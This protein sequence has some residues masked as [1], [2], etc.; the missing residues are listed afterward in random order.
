MSLLFA[1][2]WAGLHQ[3]THHNTVS[4]LGMSRV[5]PPITCRVFVMWNCAE[6]QLYFLQTGGN[7]LQFRNV[8][9]KIQIHRSG[10]SHNFLAEC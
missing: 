7:Q 9:N 4:K 8:R 6:K 5:L 2:L 1:A 10:Q 3:I